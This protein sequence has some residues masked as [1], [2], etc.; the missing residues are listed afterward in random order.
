MTVQSEFFC[1]N[2][3]LLLT[4]NPDSIIMHAMRVYTV[5]KF[6][7]VLN[8]NSLQ[9]VLQIIAA[10]GLYCMMTLFPNQEEKVPVAGTNVPTVI[11]GDMLPA[12]VLMDKNL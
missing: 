3:F 1:S 7:T 5:L 8:V 11:P 6:L 9:I 4:L 10:V 12:L 2:F